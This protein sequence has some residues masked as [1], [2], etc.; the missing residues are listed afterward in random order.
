MMFMCEVYDEYH[1]LVGHG[2]TLSLHDGHV[3]PQLVN[4][5][6]TELEPGNYT[7]RHTNEVY[8]VVLTDRIQ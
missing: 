8:L 3:R 4:N 1:R 2:W 5:N 6:N 7:V